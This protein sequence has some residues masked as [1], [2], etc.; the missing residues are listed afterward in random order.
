MPHPIPY[1]SFD[2]HCAEAM[3]FYERA[4]EGRLVAVITNGQTPMAGQFPKEHHDRVMHACLELPDGGS[5][6][7]GDCPPQ[8]GPYSGIQGLSIALNYATV[9]EAER[10]FNALAEGAQVS[11]PL[12]AS[13]WARIFGMLI[14]RYGT[15]WI[16]N[17]ES[18][19][20]PSA[21]A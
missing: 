7:A 11:M 8:A 16:I 14:D 21:T 3:R 17:G 2:G 1:L 20:T 12:Q 9:A 13:F 10:V 15:P 18:L 4:L 6:Y 19:P 5:L